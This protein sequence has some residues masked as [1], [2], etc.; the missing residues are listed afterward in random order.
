MADDDDIPP[1]FFKVFISHFSS[2]SLLIPISYYNEFPCLLPK[3]AILRGS[4]GCIWNVA[5]EIKEKPEEVYFGRGWAKFVQD[6]SLKDG[7]FLTFVY[8]GHNVYEVSIYACDGCKEIRAVTEVEDGE[9]EDTIWSLSSK[10][11]DSESDMANAI[12]RSKN[13]GKSKEE[14]VEDSDDNEDS[15]HSLDSEEGTDTDSEFMV[16][17]NPKSTKKGKLKVEV[18][19]DSDDEEDSVCSEFKMANAMSRTKKK[20]KKK[21]ETSDEEDSD[22]DYIEAFS[23]MDVEDNSNSDSSY[24]PDSEDTTANV[25][26]K[27]KGKSKV[28]EDVDANS[29]SSCSVEPGK[30]CKKVKAKIKNPE[31]YLDNPANV[32]FETGVKNRIYE[33]LVHAQLVKDYCLK[34]Q[35][36]VCYIDPIGEFKAK[37]AKWKDQRVCIKKWMCIC[38]RNKLKKK[39]RILCELL[40]KKNLVYA[41][42]LHIV[43]EKDL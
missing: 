6:N 24:L 15:V 22:S 41:I 26:P 20:G 3:T 8:N 11:T 23:N 38:E 13:K 7:D 1:R 32:Y 37:T 42:K 5:I 27:K 36:Y 9:E 12:P 16:N 18:A 17:T 33:L 30:K 28:K 4:G 25:K 21:V 10:D 31:A 43:R 19:E 29:D 14:N 34:F 2:D 35:D 40:R 39:D